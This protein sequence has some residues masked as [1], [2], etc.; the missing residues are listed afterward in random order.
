MTGGE[1]HVAEGGDV[2][3]ASAS[4]SDIHMDACSAHAV[5]LRADARQKCTRCGLTSGTGCV[6]IAIVI[7]EVLSVVSVP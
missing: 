3:L 1:K 2:N 6:D 4:C 5:D 7:K